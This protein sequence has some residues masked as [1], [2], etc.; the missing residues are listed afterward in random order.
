MRTHTC[1]LIATTPEDHED[2]PLFGRR[3]PSLPQ[4]EQQHQQQASQEVPDSIPRGIATIDDSF[5]YPITSTP[6]G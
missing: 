1:F 6:R 2:A 4:P 5:S 3:K